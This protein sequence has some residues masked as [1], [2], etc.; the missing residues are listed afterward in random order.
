MA[1]LLIDKIF[2][3]V[4]NGLPSLPI[5]I[6]IILTIAFIAMLAVTIGTL[7]SIKRAELKARKVIDLPPSAIQ[8]DNASEELIDD[9]ND[10]IPLPIGNWLNN[11]LISKGYISV[12]NV[13]RSFFKALEFMKQSLGT[14]Y[15]YKLPWFMMIGTSES[16]KSSLLSGFTHDEIFDDENEDAD[17]T[18]WFLRGGI[19]LD[20]K[21]DVFLPKDHFKANEKSWN[22]ML[23]MLSKY[24]GSKPLNGIIL[25]IPANELYGKNKL[26]IEI[27][28]QRAH[29]LSRKLNFTQNFLG[30]KL[31]IYI[32]ITKTDT[33]PG[34]Q[35]FC[36]E[37]PVRNRNNMLGWSSQYSLDSIYTSK[38]IDE[39]FEAIEDELN[40][41]RMEIFSESSITTTRDGVFV[42]PSELLTIKEN[43]AAYTDNIFKACSIEGRFYLRGIYFTGD[44][45]MI[46]LLSFAGNTDK[47]AI[48]GTPDADVNEAGSLTASFRQEEFAPK[49]IFFAE[50]LIFKKIFLEDGIASP[51]RSKVYK[52]N[53]SIFIA[54][55]STAAFVMIGSYG[56]FSSKDQLKNSKDK[57]YP[58]LFKVSSIIKNANSLTM[59]NIENNGNELLSEY[60]NQLLSMMQQLNSARLSSIFVPASWFSSINNELTETLR[61][62]Y[63]RVVV[64]TIYMNLILKSRNLLTLKPCNENISKNIGEVLNPYKSREYT[65]MK[66]YIDGL[67]ELEQNI[68]KFDSLRASGDPND[69]S[70]LV[71]YTF[72]GSLPKE[73]LD[74]YDQFRRI[75]MNTP[76]P[77]I[78]LSPYKKVA[79]EVLLNLFQNFIDAIFS[80]APN[81]SI[82]SFLNK[83]IDSIN[84][85]NIGK[86]P[87]CK[88]IQQFS[89]N[90]TTVCQ[91]LGEEGSTWLDNDYFKSDEEFD[92][93]LDNVEMLFGKEVPQKLL[94]TVAVHFGYLQSKLIKFNALLQNDIT[95]MR[96]N[97]SSED[98][99]KKSPSH[100]IFLMEKALASIC[101]EPYMKEPGK[102]RLI[103]E[104]PEGK[105]IYWDDELI[106]YAYNIGKSFE[107]FFSTSIKDF[108][109]SMQEGITLLAKA[110]LCAVIASTVAKAQSFVDAPNALTDEL[111]SEEILQKQVSELKGVAPK[112]VSLM[113]IM[114]DDNVSFV[115][116]D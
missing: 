54:K 46:P 70:N 32:V 92:G 50:D 82:I 101:K 109:K 116:S 89:S 36:S 49:K 21:G 68:K 113:K 90:L 39:A 85:Q 114:R 102:Y 18:W 14:G 24:R 8:N 62:S 79:Y 28:R 103:T 95:S 60:T 22:I 16:G 26:S 71:D 108:P 65:L 34:F 87:N 35:S 29:F 45:K 66:S 27:I 40:E 77:P 47:V 67:I 105:M 72:Q 44:S 9:E 99:N 110:N 86:I 10:R 69:L 37:I 38:W 4:K 12:H 104:I 15:K 57:L 42:F 94:D 30:M 3:A 91:E 6:G 98:Y 81:G 53:K 96:V 83:F 80:D 13:V 52:S 78:D 11:I 93:F 48:M 61:I 88:V 23:K 111:T 55:V 73:F 107:Q 63:Q 1:F 41:I 97:T 25:S 33:I 106:Q 7:I 59:K 100:G 31:P 2:N 20:V 115:F 5:L 51:L 17:I 76:F 56:L 74:N 19:I 58:S 75:L 84:K 43:L 64:R 112:F